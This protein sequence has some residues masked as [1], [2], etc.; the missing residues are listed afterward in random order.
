MILWYVICLGFIIAFLYSIRLY[1]KSKKCN[2]STLGKIIE[3][4]ETLRYAK[5]GPYVDYQPTYQYMVDGKEYINKVTMISSN[6]ERYKLNKIV[7]IYYEEGNPKNFI[8]SDEIIYIKR[9]IILHFLMLLFVLCLI[10]PA[11][12]DLKK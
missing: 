7:L 1:Y 11:L 12:L 9:N 5:S 4:K 10:A 3:I 8:P 6:T 2:C